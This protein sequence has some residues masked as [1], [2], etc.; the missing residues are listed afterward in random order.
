MSTMEWW[1]RLFP[2]WLRTTIWS[3]GGILAALLI[4]GMMICSLLWLARILYTS[5]TPVQSSAQNKALAVSAT[6]TSTDATLSQN[7]TVAATP[8]PLQPTVTPTPSTTATPVPSP[9]TATVTPLPLIDT[10][11]ALY[12]DEI[13]PVTPTPTPTDTPLPPVLTF[14]PTQ[15]PLPPLPTSTTTPF[16]PTA[17]S[18]TF[19]TSTPTTFPTSTPTTFPT[20]PIPT[21]IPTPILIP[22]TATP[23]LSFVRPTSTPTR[24]FT[25][26][27]VTSTA[28]FTTTP[29]STPVPPVVTNL[30]APASAPYLPSGTLILLSPLSLDLPSYGLTYFEWEWIGDPLAPRF[31]F[32]VSVWLEGQA[33]A[34]V[35]NAVRDNTT[36]GD[37]EQIGR[38]RY[39]LTVSNIRYAAGVSGRSG[40]YLW[41]VGI[42]QVNPG[43]VDYGLEANPARMRY[44]APRTD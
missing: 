40:T 37:L 6:L 43:Y 44:V 1:E 12:R 13:A 28:T 7:I 36:K 38:N 30:T 24:R 16:S 8:T 14:T 42:V 25:L 2:P 21:P 17:T 20:I 19:P 23:T 10:V 29:T 18:T 5:T 3:V 9:S 4:I 34:G 32:E 22:P 27:T 26:P 33:R 15:T 35:H 11:E 39:R 31:G 41:T